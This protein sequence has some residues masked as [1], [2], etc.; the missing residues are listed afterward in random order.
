MDC[1]QFQIESQQ[2]IYLY[3]TIVLDLQDHYQYQILLIKILSYGFNKCNGFNGNLNIP[4]S[5][6]IVWKNIHFLHVQDLKDHYKT[7]KQIVK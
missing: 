1:Y 4:D 7:H 2:S 3:F 5:V 6:I